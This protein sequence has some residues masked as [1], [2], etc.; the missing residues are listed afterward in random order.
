MTTDPLGILARASAASLLMIT[1]EYWKVRSIRSPVAGTLWQE[2]S[3]L[4][5]QTNAIRVGGQSIRMAS[6]RESNRPT[7][8]LSPLPQ[9]L[10]C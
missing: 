4:R 2:P 1:P 7:V 6:N 10:H 5:L 8:F 3:P 9:S